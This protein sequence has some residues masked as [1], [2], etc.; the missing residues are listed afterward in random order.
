M[1][2]YGRGLGESVSAV[3]VLCLLPFAFGLLLSSHAWGAARSALVLDVR[4][5][6]GPA[7]ADYVRRGLHAAAAR[8]AAVV[9]LELDTPGGLDIAM[10]EIV[11]AILASPVPVVA[12]VAPSGARA[13]SAGTYIL[14]AC[15]V[16]AMAPGTNLGAATPVRIGGSSAPAGGKGTPPARGGSGDAMKHKMVNDAAAYIRSLAELRGRNAEWGE[17]AV[18]EAASL[19]AEDA[20]KHHVIDLMAV[21]VPQ[22]LRR[23]DGRTVQVAGGVERTLHTR[24]LRV[25]YRGPGWRTRLLGVVT[26]PDVAYILM[27]VGIYGL[28]FEFATP[29]YVLPGV[30]GAVSL[31]L[32]LYAFQVLPINYAGLALLLLGVVFMVAEAFVPSFGTLGIGGLVSF[33]AGS[34]MLFDTG[35][36]DYEVAYPLIAG[37][38]LASALFLIGAVGLIVKAR[39]NPVVSGYEGLIHARGEVLEGFEREGRVRVHGEVW[40]A[41]ARGGPL[42][43]GQRV[44]VTG[45]DGLTLIVE[46]SAGEDSH[47]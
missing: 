3:R 13:A 20:L 32:A 25:E 26:H 40:A 22:L 35:A 34:V 28:L 41:R 9:I 4:G 39:R 27:L 15:Q 8:D 33:V 18:R 46:P 19:P 24:G 31:L 47:G 44:R 29:G 16:A 17:R 7:T 14:Y 12:Y 11:R 23:L 45:R 1:L 6:I 10:R 21:D 42:H 30:T 36:G 2:F 38:A 37:V 5:V 43:A